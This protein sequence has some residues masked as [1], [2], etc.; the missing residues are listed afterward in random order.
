[1]A[2]IT[3]TSELA[4]RY[5]LNTRI[6]DYKTYKKGQ[7]NDPLIEIK[8]ANVSEVSI[9][10]DTTWAT[11]GQSH[12]NIVAFNNPLTGSFKL[13]TQIL[14]SQ[15]IAL[16][17]GEDVASE[18]TEVTFKNTELSTMPSYYVIESDTVWQSKDG[19]VCDEKLTFHK[20]MAKRAYN[21]SYNGDGDPV[22]VDI[23]FEL[24]QNDENEVLTTSRITHTTK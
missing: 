15:L 2:G 6:Y 16:M 23:E 24:G 5:G 1:M 3:K 20:A 17:A 18:T 13:S 19:E 7:E 9:S 10:G 21:I 12:G 14:T 4:N 22:S 8:F 11:G